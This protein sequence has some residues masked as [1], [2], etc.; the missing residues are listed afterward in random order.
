MDTNNDLIAAV[1][2]GIAF[3]AMIVTIFQ[4]RNATAAANRSADADE[5]IAALTQQQFASR[6][7]TESLGASRSVAATVT[8]C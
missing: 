4:T 8:P 7:A 3:V 1:S 6:L 5:R 2:A